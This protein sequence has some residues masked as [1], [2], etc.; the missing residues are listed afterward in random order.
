MST[1]EPKK[2]KK[3]KQA[4]LDNIVEKPTHLENWTLGKN[5]THYKD[6]YDPTL[7]VPIL[8][9]ERRK[10]YETMFGWD[11]W[12]AFE[13]SCLLDSGLPAFKVL[14]ITTNA[15]STN[16]F[17]SKSLKL[18]LN[19][20]N[21]T[22]FPTVEDAV[23]Q[24]KK[25]LSDLAGSEVLVEMVSSLDAPQPYSTVLENAF[26]AASCDTYEYNVN[27]LKAVDAKDNFFKSYSSNLL[28]SNCEITNQPDWA[29]IYI[30][31]QPDALDVDP[32]SLLKYIVSYRNHQEFHEPTCERIYQD[33]L[34]ILK[35]R[36]L[37]VIC[38]YTRRGGI[39][40]NPIRVMKDHRAVIPVLPK[41]LQQ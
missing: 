12:T 19:S 41:L 35:P 15:N 4:K 24:I 37:V 6:K 17:E 28:R 32:E 23:A 38:Q 8:R 1:K 5:D 40:I 9:G 36:D 31:Y 39:D 14:R 26:P 30:H 27:L 22:K 25:D 7:L 21:N 16:I 11:V 29:N 33:L 20:Y 34:R 13:F 18:Y 2:T 10:G 3:T